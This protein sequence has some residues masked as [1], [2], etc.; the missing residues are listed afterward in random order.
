MKRVAQR[1]TPNKDMVVAKKSRMMLSLGQSL[2]AALLMRVGFMVYGLF[3]DVSMKVKYTDVDYYVF[4][5]AARYM[6]QVRQCI[7]SV[8]KG[9]KKEPSLLNDL[10]GWSAIVLVFIPQII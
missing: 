1:Q 5:D 4:T 6:T 7:R 9:L 2:S 8:L 3:Q 10:P